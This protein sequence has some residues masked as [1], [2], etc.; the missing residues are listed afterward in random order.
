MLAVYEVT[1]TE[2]SH[3]SN[4]LSGMDQ[5][6]A[7]GVDR[8]SISLSE[9]GT[10]HV[11]LGAW[12]STICATGNWTGIELEYHHAAELLPCQKLQP[13]W[14]PSAIRCVMMTTMKV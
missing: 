4:Y 9:N 12:P 2:G 8:I 11:S 6:V 5:D 1:W 10:M 13:D 14:S 3:T 7:N